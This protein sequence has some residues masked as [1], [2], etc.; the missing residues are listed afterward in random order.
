MDQLCLITSFSFP[1]ILTPLSFAFALIELVSLCFCLRGF[2]SQVA[3]RLLQNSS[4]VPWQAHI[5][6]SGI[7]WCS[8]PPTGLH[9]S[10]W[11]SW[12]KCGSHPL[13]GGPLH[14]TRR[15]PGC[16]PLIWAEAES[17]HSTRCC[18]CTFSS[19]SSSSP[20]HSP[21]KPDDV[22]ATEAQQTGC[23]VACISEALNV[24]QFSNLFCSNKVSFGYS[25]SR[26]RFSLERTTEK[27]Y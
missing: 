16:L 22:G 14:G 19:A 12:N 25:S 21:S 9:V 20:V 8:C 11:E 3:E 23:Q 24:T 7:L 2:S 13:M 27:Q 10:W 5:Q 6:S 1:P 4:S 15:G 18:S 26:P 17:R